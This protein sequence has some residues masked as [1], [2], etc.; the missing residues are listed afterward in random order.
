MAEDLLFPGVLLHLEDLGGHGQDE[1]EHGAE[2]TQHHD[3]SNDITDIHFSSCLLLPD[4]QAG[5][6]HERQGHQT[7]GD[8]GDGEALKRLGI[9]REHQALPDAGEQHD[10]QQE[11]QAAVI[12]L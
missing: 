4:L 10:G 1:A 2:D 6:A 11:A 8:Q 3:G 7:C 5:E 12:S 9:V